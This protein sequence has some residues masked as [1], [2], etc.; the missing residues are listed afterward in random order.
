[1]T[2]F[3]LIYGFDPSILDSILNHP[4]LPEDVFL[5]ISIFRI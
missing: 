3:L 2:T 5:N 1:M 4:L